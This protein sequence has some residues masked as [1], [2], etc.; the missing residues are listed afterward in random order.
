[1]NVATATACRRLLAVLAIATFG[2]NFAC[3]PA[4]SP[5]SATVVFPGKLDGRA[6]IAQYNVHSKQCRVISVAPA[7]QKFA[8]AHYLSNDELLVL[9]NQPANK[10]VLVVT[11]HSLA[12]N[13]AELPGPFAIAG[14]DDAIH[15]LLLP[16]VVVAGQLFLGGKHLTRVD[17]ATGKTLR[18]D[19]PDETN[20]ILLGKRGDGICYL[21]TDQRNKCQWEL[22]TIDPESLARTTLF[23]SPAITADDPGWAVLPVPCFHQDLR[24]VAIPGERTMQESGDSKHAAILVFQAGKLEHVMPISPTGEDVAIGSLAWTHDGLGL[25][26]VVA[27]RTENGQ[28]FSLYE[29]SLGEGKAR[30]TT[31]LEV[32]DNEEKPTDPAPILQ[33]QLAMSPD[34]KW[35]AVTTSF[36]AEQAKPAHALLLV[37][38]SGDE[39]TVTTVPF[40]T[41]K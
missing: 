39:R 28:R 16:P 36:V 6:A 31:L 35:A 19:R 34:S 1:M 10:N 21:A 2:W 20:E 41:K 9:A 13:T 25:L 37:N 7:D 38:V 3:R 40:P 4:W 29:R 26:T 32:P 22:G 18:A 14:E 27:R 5:D 23:R 12:N 8:L 17:L 24:R 15:H 33:M 30:E 11:R